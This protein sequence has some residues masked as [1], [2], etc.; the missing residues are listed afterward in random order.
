MLNI[1]DSLGVQ[2]LHHMASKIMWQYENVVMYLCLQYKYL[3]I[4]VTNQNMI[5]EEMT[6][7]GQCLL[8]FSPEPF[9]LLSAD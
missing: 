7:F 1:L 3:S 9:I 6:E 8:P 2:S 4:T 5:H